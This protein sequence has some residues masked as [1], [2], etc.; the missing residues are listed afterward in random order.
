MRKENY[1]RH[2]YIKCKCQMNKERFY[3][4]MKVLPIVLSNKAEFGTQV[5]KG[6]RNHT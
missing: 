4:L 3:I 5:N 1:T 2:F 6:N